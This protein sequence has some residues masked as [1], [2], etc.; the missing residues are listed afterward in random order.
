MRGD[1]R[2]GG[3]ALFTA[4]LLAYGAVAWRES[5]DR[6]LAA[7]GAEGRALLGAVAAGVEASLE[8]SRTVE[9][10]LGE[11]LAE[12]ARDLAARLAASP[13][14]E[15]QVLRETVDRRALAGAALLDPE[16]GCVASAEAGRA[17]PSF[18]AADPFAASRFERFALDALAHRIRAAEAGDTARGA[19]D[20]VVVGFGDG[21]FAATTE[22][23]VA[24]RDASLPGVVVL[25]ADATRLAEFRRDAGI[26]RVLRES[27]AAP[28]VAFLAVQAADGTCLAS[29][30]AD[31]VGAVLPGAPAEPSWR[32]DHR[33][34]RTLDLA[35]PIAWEGGPRGHLR[36][37]LDAAPVEDV[38]VRSRTHLAVA[39]AAALCAGIGG[40]IALALVDRRRARAEQALRTQIELRER[41]ASLGRLAAGVA[42]EVRGP[43][44][45]LSLSSQLLAREAAARPGESG[46][47]V[48]S[49]TAEIRAAV[50]RID[51][52][53]RDF[54]ALGR[55][56]A[57]AARVR[58]DLADLVSDAAAAE[59]GTL[60]ISPPAAAVAVLADRP[61][62][63]RAVANLVRNARQFA[64]PES[65]EVSW[66][67]EGGRAV[68][69]VDDA[70]PGVPEADRDVVF[71]P[72]RTTRA[73]GTGL[74]L[75]L[76]REAVEQHG[77]RIEL[78]RS[79]AGGAR[80]RIVLPDGGAAACAAAAHVEAGGP[81]GRSG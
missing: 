72:F 43:L 11:R 55:D 75:A 51:A 81:A 79:P 74:G 40:L 67:S 38:I 14:F 3:G 48:A 20:P 53:V 69:D 28:A 36:V 52:V 71:E 19:D 2:A 41:F 57:P 63:A 29:D 12:A 22:F 34:R 77:G 49:L 31:L 18:D 17:E 8:A 60:R 6:A 32:T 50:G 13:G 9:S 37:A 58:V 25:R 24:L 59:G 61:L 5:E 80:F 56:S 30:D 76:A 70:G 4:L 16:L 54:L 45:A 65:V 35:V 39:T 27:A 68:L 73:G 42:H 23:A 78:H 46:G 21:P 62:L 64:P 44:N 1:L 26:G 66:R 7:A 33:G 47:R 15:E 10:L